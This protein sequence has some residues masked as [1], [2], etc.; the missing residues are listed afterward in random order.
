MTGNNLKRRD[1]LHISG[2]VALGSALI[3]PFK[4]V[5]A[6]ETD[7]KKEKGFKLSRPRW[8]IYENGSYDLISSEIIL[9]N[10]RPSIN[11]QGVMPRN[12]FLGDSPKGKRIVYELPEGFL[13]LDLKTNSDSISIGAELSGFSR[14]PRW[15]HPISQ[16]EVF[17]VNRF[18][19]QGYGTGNEC[20]V[21][22][23][24]RLE[25]LS[26]NILMNEATWSHDSY[27]SFAFLGKN[28][29][30]A[31]GNI[32]HSRFLHRSTIYNRIHQKGLGSQVID[33]EKIFFESG[34]LLED[35]RIDNEYIKL[36]ELYFYTGNRAY[37][38]ML[39]L[40]WKISEGTNARQSSITSYHWISKT[41]EANSF[42]KIQT[43]I[44]YL[45]NLKPPIPLHSVIINKGYCKIGDWLEPN[46][47]WPGGLDRAA[48]EI[49]KDGYRAGIW[50]APFVVAEDSKL[51]SQHPDWTIKNYQDKPI[52]RNIDGEG[53]F[54]ALDGSH[55]G[56][57]KYLR[58]V[59]GE[60]RK[61]GYIFYETAFMDW[62]LIDSWDIK[63]AK[64]GKTS[65]Q[66]FHDVLQL[67]REEIGMGSMWMM[68]RSPYGASI[69]YADIVRINKTLQNPEEWSAP[70][71]QNM[72][73]ESYY[74]HYFN[75]IFWQNSPGE[76]FLSDSG[77]NLS[78]NGILS[79]ALWQG[80]LGG[81][82]GTNEEL[83]KLDN[84]K[85]RFFRFLEPNK[86]QQNAYLPFWPDEDEIKV[87]VRVYKQNRSWGVLFFNDKEGPVERTFN[88]ADLIEKDDTFVYGWY[89]EVPM[90][91]GRLAEI[92]ITLEPHQ[93]RLFYFSENN[94][95]PPENLTL[96]GKESDGL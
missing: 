66:V 41:N 17:G 13:M 83:E 5:L 68:D 60:L 87:A 54:Y 40:A 61:S 9:K 47:N 35:I 69:G 29:T 44:E 63:R 67:I 85:I 33:D 8:I 76:I 89:P 25:G 84:K 50:I 70:G 78:E 23:I 36:P 81:A 49:F 7:K 48:R 16:A 91:F 79:L 53:T 14:A 46:E 57:Q 55:P 77:G 59:F 39:E 12:V 34:M 37:E 15:F 21:F 42:E 38:T 31:I 10:C 27:L 20:G 2:T 45:D 64:P 74:S 26:G 4:K 93:S 11:G 56:F 18:F 94:E 62:G 96:G 88:I 32:D 71:I 1:F 92:K 72:I 52:P 19:K 65:V 28:E 22:P 6:N 95:Y 24:P 82:I 86:R 80:I 51:F 30:I 43:K 73:K 75:N 3:F 58:K 90:P